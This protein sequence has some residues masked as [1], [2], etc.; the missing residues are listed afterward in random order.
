MKQQVEL[1]A[2]VPCPKNREHSTIAPQPT[3]H[4]FHTQA[5]VLIMRGKIWFSSWR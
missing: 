5:K 4:H 3:H 2:I 1:F